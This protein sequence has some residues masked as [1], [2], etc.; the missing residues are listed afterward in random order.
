[1]KLISEA[2]RRILRDDPIVITVIG[3]D[4]DDEVKVYDTVAKTN[5]KAPFITVT[6]VPGATAVE[7]YGD[8]EVGHSLVYQVSSWGR[9]RVEAWE[10]AEAADQALKLGDWTVDPYTM[11]RLHRQGQP[12]V[13]GDRD[14][15]WLQVIAI[16]DVFLAR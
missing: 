12:S 10:V 13:L 15:N 3:K 8:D 2:C 11:Q 14:T 7:V 4:V 16:Y 6:L 9:N 5:V 1:M